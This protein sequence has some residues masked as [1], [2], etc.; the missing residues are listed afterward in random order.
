MAAEGGL[1]V[2]PGTNGAHCYASQF[3]RTFYQ[4]NSQY[5]AVCAD[6]N[7]QFYCS[8]NLLALRLD[9]VGWGGSTL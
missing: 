9:R 2:L 5:V 3:G 1:T 6:E 7:F 4:V 8:L